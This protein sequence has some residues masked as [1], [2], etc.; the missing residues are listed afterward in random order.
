M[1]EGEDALGL[2][3]RAQYVRAP[4]A[5]CCTWSLIQLVPGHGQ[6]LAKRQRGDHAQDGVMEAEGKCFSNTLH[7]VPGLHIHVVYLFALAA[8]CF[9]VPT[10]T[11]E[12]RAKQAVED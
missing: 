12:E 6:Q 8:G 9:T 2:D 11:A 1:G 3:V 4:P 10:A 5:M 7:A